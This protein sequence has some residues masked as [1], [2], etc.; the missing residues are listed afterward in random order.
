MIEQTILSY[1][2]TGTTE[3]AS[4]MDACI[5]LDAVVNGIPAVVSG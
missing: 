1:L 3:T 5:F 4:R 2:I